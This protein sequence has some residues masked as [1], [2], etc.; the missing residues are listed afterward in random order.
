MKRHFLLASLLAA[1]IATPALAAGDKFDRTS[2]GSK[3]VITSGNLF[4]TNNQLQGSDTGL[5]YLKKAAA[6]VTGQA[7]VQLNGTGLQY[8]AVAVGNIAGGNNAFVK[9]QSQDG[10]GMFDHGGFYVGNNSGVLFFT[11]DAPMASPATL[12]VVLT[13]NVATMTIKSSSG[14]QVYQFDYGQNFGT[15]GGLGTFGPISLDN[16]KSRT[17]VEDAFAPAPRK[18][19]MSDAIDLSL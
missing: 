3:W 11:L 7:L 16:F 13:G 12:K 2:L 4:I 14:T 6:G 10:G 8:G 19:M 17:S 1:A 15:G 18:V 5:G 9:I